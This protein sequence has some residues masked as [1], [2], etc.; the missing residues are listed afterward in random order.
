MSDLLIAVGGTG[1]H[2]AL[3]VSRL[4][5]LGAL[6]KMEV[7]IIDADDN[8]E[9]SVSLKTFGNTLQ[10]GYTI[11]PLENGEKIFPPF[12]KA[13]KEDP[14]FHELFLSAHPEPLQKDIFEVCFDEQ[15]A[16]IHVKDG[17][18]GRPAVGATVF[19]HNKDTLLKAVFERVNLANNIFIAGSMVGGT[20]AGM[21]HQITK[22]IA[23]PGRRVYGL[24]F[25]RW[26]SVP[27]TAQKQTI[28][29]GTLDRNMRY[30]LDYFFRDTRP[31]L[32]ASLLIGLPDH[33]PSPK[34][35]QISLEAGK[36][37]EKKHYFHLVTAHG[38]LK[39]QKIAVIEA[40]DGSGYAAI[41]DSDQP[42][43][44]Y[45]SDW[46]GR[47]LHWY[48][49]RGLFVKEV[50]DYASSPKFKKEI[51]SAFGFLGSKANIGRGLYEAIDQY[52]KKQRETKI[53]EIIRTWTMLSK[54]YRFALSWLD[55]VLD[56]MPES[57][58]HSSYTKVKVSEAEK[59]NVVQTIWA[60]SLVQGQEVLSP[61]EVAHRLHALLVNHFA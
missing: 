54:Q 24:I 25:L 37:D 38:V 5:F 15:S 58:H 13:I 23:A 40:T 3:A 51:D 20:G 31:L 14:E 42:Y 16:A 8:Q 43:Q 55:E 45:E 18:F 12:D 53:G 19:A 56:S 26:F 57:F 49:N 35:G 44:M 47:P 4:V 30:G 50:L 36:N 29:D 60:K 17:M 9:L 59:A 22:Q 32:K 41:F 39:L 28:N 61:A 33:P 11:H 7:A 34:V 2:V 6:P 21:L 46:N 27:R 1:Q 48:V 10:E 52:E